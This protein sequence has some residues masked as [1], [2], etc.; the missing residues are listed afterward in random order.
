MSTSADMSLPAM[1]G[2]L[3]AGEEQAAEQPLYEGTEGNFEPLDFPRV[4]GEVNETLFL[5]APEPS[6]GRVATRLYPDQILAVLVTALSCVTRTGKGYPG[7]LRQE[8]IDALC[9]VFEAEPAW[10]ESRKLLK[11]IGAV[12]LAKLFDDAKAATKGSRAG[13][14]THIVEALSAHLDKA[15]PA[16]A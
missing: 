3:G 5:G 14:I 12:D 9:A 8:L 16:A 6:D 15:I 2:V 1:Y 4:Q 11:A 10:L 7:Y 13:S